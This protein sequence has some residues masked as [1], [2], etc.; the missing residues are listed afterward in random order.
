VPGGVGGFG[1]PAPTIPGL[2]FPVAWP[3]HA[4]PGQAQAQ[5]QALGLAPPLGLLPPLPTQVSG[6]PVLAAQPLAPPANDGG[7]TAAVAEAAAALNQLGYGATAASTAPPAVAAPAGDPALASALAS[8]GLTPGSLA[9]IPGLESL[10]NVPGLESLLGLPQAGVGSTGVGIVP[11]RSRVKGKGFPPKGGKGMPKGKPSLQDLPVLTSQEVQE[12]QVFVT[13]AGQKNEKKCRALLA[14]KDFNRMDD[15]DSEQRTAV[16]ICI[17]KKM[18]ED[19]CLSILNRDD[20]TEVNAVDQFGYTILS[21]AASNGMVSVC[22]AVLEH[23]EFTQV[24]SKDKWGAT[25]LH[26]AA[27]SNLGAVCSAI[28]EHPAFVEAHVVAFSFKFENQTA[29]Q[30]AEERGCSD[31]EQAIKK[32]LTG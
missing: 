16:H 21:L 3:G 32:A 30:V 1:T 17:L 7:W 12:P 13:A 6:L 11:S 9:N 29:L 15:K 14:H 8:L 28:L 10:A 2:A 4:L 5:A 24:N 26:W 22:K 19:I 31:A 27:A 25:A 23:P 20:F 18:P